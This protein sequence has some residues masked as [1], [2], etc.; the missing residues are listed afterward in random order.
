MRYTNH[1]W[2][3][4]LAAGILLLSGVRMEAQ[5]A[6][7]SGGA[8]DSKSGR[9]LNEFVGIPAHALPP[10]VRVREHPHGND[11]EDEHHAQDNE[12][13]EEAAQHQ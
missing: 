13:T 4:A 2:L 8:I 1:R 6:G 7:E 10:E 12:E 11:A 3:A 9:F 5:R